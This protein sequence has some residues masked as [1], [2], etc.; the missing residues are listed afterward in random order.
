MI[1]DQSTI[2]VSKSLIIPLII[3][4]YVKFFNTFKLLSRLKIFQYFV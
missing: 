4:D 1:F 2:D 3:S